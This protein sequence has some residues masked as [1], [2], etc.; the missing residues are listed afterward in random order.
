[1]ALRLS[2]WY[3]LPLLL[4]SILVFGA[5]GQGD[6]GSSADGAGEQLS[7][8]VLTLEDLP[9]GYLQD[10]SQFTT[11]E[12]LALGDQEKLAKLEEQGRILGYSVSFT[13]GDVSATDAPFFG[14]ESA[15]SLYETEGG[16][17]DSFAEAVEEARG[18]DWEAILGFG[19]TELEEIDRPITDEMLWIR[20]T[21]VVELGEEQTPVLVIDDQVLMRQGPARSFLRVSSAME[22]S[23]DR[24]AL[25][26]EIAAL[27]EQQTRRVGGEGD[28]DGRSWVLIVAVVAG[29]AVALAV[30]GTGAVWWRRRAASRL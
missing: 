16:A 20:V 6:D 30:A 14:V 10:E 22:G 13:R 26:E 24:S 15:A 5:F 17:S 12:E 1:M 23:S 21:G 27:A 4:G 18:T 8:M 25:L 9:D 11:N 29:V 2:G 3:L 7:E 28:E 19:E